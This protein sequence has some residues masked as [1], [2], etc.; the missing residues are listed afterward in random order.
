MKGELVYFPYVLLQLIPH[1]L[2]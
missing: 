1:F 2:N